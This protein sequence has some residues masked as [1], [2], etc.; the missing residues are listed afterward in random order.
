MSTSTSTDP[1]TSSRESHG[2]EGRNRRQRRVSYDTSLPA[3][4]SYLGTDLVDVQGRTVLDDDY[5]V[6]LP[7]LSLPGLILVPGQV[8]PL[9]LQHPALVGMMRKI[10]SGDKVFGLTSSLPSSL[11][12]FGTTAEVRSFSDIPDPG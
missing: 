4:H 7:L 1:R 8:L 2:S 11:S 3:Q 12:E 10:I 9:Q 6:T 5:L